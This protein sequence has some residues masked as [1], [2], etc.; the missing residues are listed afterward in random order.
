MT[1]GSILVVG[2][3]G[4]IGS[5]MCLALQDAGYAV[6]VFDNLS[7]GH[8][9]AVGDTTLIVGDI[10][11]PEQVGACLAGGK[12]DLVMHF[13]AMAY[14]G[15]S[16]DEPALYYSNNVAGSLCLLDAMRVAGIGRLVFSSTCAT[17]GDPVERPMT[18]AHP[19]N[20]VNP[21]GRGKLMIEQVL[22]DYGR[23]YGMQSISLRYFNASGCDPAG[24]A[25]ERH[26]PETHLIPLVLEQALRVK[27]GAPAEE[28]S[29][30][31][32]G[33][34]FPTE[35]G[36]CVRDYIHVSDLC[37]AHLLAAERLIGGQVEGAEA[38]N[39][40]NGRG[41]SVLEVIQAARQVTGVDIR[42]RM[43]PRRAGDPAW[44]V[45]SAWKAAD[46]LRWEPRIAD[47]E[48]I[49]AT[50]W[51]WMLRSRAECRA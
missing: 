14:V 27:E 49:I 19:Q 33:D 50:A 6:T 24:R 23:A 3:A 51:D 44:L 43:A 41:Y 26:A 34:D 35:D 48:A 25:G 7:R 10:R 38:Y 12:Y 42:Y 28:T 36:T 1:A 29:L 39:L 2:G 22:A 5:H 8:R 40:G 21:Y 32:L 30:M 15:E 16:V 18:E 20:P 47:I 45:G 31:V 11:S 13:A 17:Y 4:Y 37:R 46:V 9:D